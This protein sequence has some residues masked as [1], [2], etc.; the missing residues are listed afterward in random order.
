MVTALQLVVKIRGAI[1]SSKDNRVLSSH[2]THRNENWAEP[3]EIDRDAMAMGFTVAGYD[4]GSKDE[5]AV[6]AKAHQR[7]AFWPDAYRGLPNSILR[8]ALFTIN[9]RTDELGSHNKELIA[10]VGDVTIKHTGPI[11]N[12]SD[13]DVWEECIHAS[14][15]DLGKEIHVSSNKMLTQ[16]GRSVNSKAYNSLSNSLSKLVATA[17]TIKIGRFQYTGTLVHHHFLDEKTGENIITLNPN[18]AVLFTKGGWTAIDSSDNRSLKPSQLAQWLHRHYSTHDVPFPYKIETIHELSGSQIKQMKHFKLELK[19]AAAKI[20]EIEGWTME[21]V[22]DKLIV[23]KPSNK[24][25]SQK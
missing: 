3:G 5:A 11:L 16:L 8:S 9:N 21:V 14:G 15:G 19:K 22:D 10:S 6:K 2:I 24:T 25:L 23:T 18:L 17:V 12:Q 7:L 4:E 1:L 13:L 20:S